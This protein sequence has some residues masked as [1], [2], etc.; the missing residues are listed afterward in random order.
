M[1]NEELLQVQQIQL[2]MAKEVRRICEKHGIE[3][4]LESG[5]MLG[6]VRHKGV[7][8]WDDDLDLGMMRADYKRFM[9]IAPKEIDPQYIVEEWHSEHAYGM[10]FGKIVKNGTLY[11]ETI[12]QKCDLNHG[13]FIDIFPFDEIPDDPEIQKK[14]ARKQLFLWKL[15]RAK[16]KYRTWLSEGF[17]DRKRYLKNIPYRMLASVL[18]MDWLKNAYDRECQ[19][20]NDGTHDMLTVQG[21]SDCLRW[22]FRKSWF[23]SMLDM[24]YEDTRFPVPC[25]YDAILTLYYKDYMTP[26][27]ENKRG[28]RHGI[29]KFQV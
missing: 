12:S 24:E 16:C 2:E 8:P 22:K 23:E 7:I 26:P 25:G 17:V 28:N 15:I 6:A 9:E 4:F 20:Y 3:Y 14:M 18:S 19:K 21:C 5:T 10:P 27:P 13:I 1:T 29:V 11:V